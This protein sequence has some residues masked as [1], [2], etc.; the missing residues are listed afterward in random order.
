MSTI[1]RATANTFKPSSQYHVIKKRVSWHVQGITQIKSFFIED[2]ESG[3]ET[4]FPHGR[5][6]IQIPTSNIRNFNEKE[7]VPFKINSEN[8]RKRTGLVRQ[9]PIR[10]NY[11]DN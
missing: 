9:G 8:K 1:L 3:C 5:H 2:D 11:C 4:A 7:S 6:F 10:Y